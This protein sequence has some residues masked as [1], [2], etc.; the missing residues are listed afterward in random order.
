MRLPQINSYVA[1][2]GDK[3]LVSSFKNRHLIIQQKKRTFFSVVVLSFCK[4]FPVAMA[5]I[6]K[7]VSLSQNGV[8]HNKRKDR[9][10]D[11]KRERDGMTV[12]LPS[13]WTMTNAT[14][15]TI[16]LLLEE[17]N[18]A[19]LFT[20]LL[21]CKC[22]TLKHHFTCITTIDYVNL[23]NT[24]SLHIRDVHFNT[25]IFFSAYQ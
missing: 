20:V 2:M 23:R 12:L 4:W 24:F 15:W 16:P 5:A 17:V 6:Q 21:N 25:S 8:D 22:L 19:T 9:V 10:G 13:L 18:V 1:L 7:R 14:K 3:Y 11:G